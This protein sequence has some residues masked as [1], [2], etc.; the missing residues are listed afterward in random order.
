MK[1]TKNQLKQIIKEE[2][3]EVAEGNFEEEHQSPRQVFFEVIIPALEA[4]GY[5]GLDAMKVA[6]DAVEAAFEAG[7]EM[8]APP[9]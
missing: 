7:A 5:T 2:L 1:I 4:A 8:M 3:A 9:E 6:R